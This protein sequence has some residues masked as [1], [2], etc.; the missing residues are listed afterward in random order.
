MFINNLPKLGKNGD[1]RYYV[2]IV[3]GGKVTFQKVRCI[4]RLY[5][6]V[7]ECFYI[8]CEVLEILKGDEL[9]GKEYEFSPSKD[10][11]RYTIADHAW[12]LQETIED[13]KKLLVLIALNEK[14]AYDKVPVWEL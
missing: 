9:Y 2:F 11:K 8:K 14:S 1:I 6:K 7:N 12:E 4:S 10:G 13:A 3:D 5:D